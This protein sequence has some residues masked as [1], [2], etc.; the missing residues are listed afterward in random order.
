MIKKIIVSTSILLIFSLI[1]LFYNFF[2]QK[3][4]PDE[5]TQFALIQKLN[6]E[7]FEKLPDST[8]FQISGFNHTIK[9]ER[10]E[11]QEIIGKQTM[12]EIYNE[13]KRKNIYDIYV[14]TDKFDMYV[15]SDDYA[16]YTLKN[17]P[18]LIKDFRVTQYIYF[19]GGTLT[20]SKLERMEK[21]YKFEE[22][23]KIKDKWYKVVYI[24]NSGRS[25]NL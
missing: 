23:K 5:K 16:I 11:F 12:D 18:L 9:Y 19:K 20:K 14:K 15:D 3:R 25:F 4:E 17:E 8:I 1:F 22:F 13:I 7:L 6:T 24:E 2:S 21:I 10:E